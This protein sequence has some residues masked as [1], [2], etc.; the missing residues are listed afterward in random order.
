[1]AAAR[2]ARRAVPVANDAQPGTVNN[3]LLSVN[4]NRLNNP[5]RHR[6]LQSL[7]FIGPHFSQAFSN[8]IPPI[9]T[10]N[11]LIQYISRHS[12]S[13]N[14]A[15]LRRILRNPTYLIG[16]RCVGKRTGPQSRNPPHNY[17]LLQ[18]NKM[19]Y[20]S[21]IV[22]LLRNMTAVQQWRLIPRRGRRPAR[23]EN[24]IPSLIDGRTDIQAYP[25]RC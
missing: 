20:N 23:W 24:R 1:M 10:L 16:T 5:P 22:Y 19:A 8:E 6:R 13:E 9:N 12:K 15:F 3:F 21:I 18:V 7:L 14:Q 25:L 2:P 17:A 11:Q 4:F